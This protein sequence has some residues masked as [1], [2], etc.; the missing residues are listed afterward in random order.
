M[1]GS[2]QA[3]VNMFIYLHKNLSLIYLLSVFDDLKTSRFD[4]N[5][6]CFSEVHGGEEMTSKESWAITLSILV[7]EERVPFNNKIYD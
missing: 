3:L 6:F 1:L 4:L 7:S 5:I 2:T